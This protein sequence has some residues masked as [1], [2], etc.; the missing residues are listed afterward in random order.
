MTSE[1]LKGLE[2]GDNHFM[3]YTLGDIAEFRNGKAI[4]P[5]FYS[6][7]GKHPVFGSNG[8]IARTDEVLNPN[9]VIA[10]GRVG[11]FCG[12]VYRIKESSWVT[13]N[14]IIVEP[15]S[16]TDLVFLYYRLKSLDLNRTAIGSAQP[17]V[18]QSGLKIIRTIIP[19]LPEQKAIASILGALDDKIELN[20]KTND[21]LEA[22]ARA[23]FKSWFTYPFEGVK[24][25]PSP[26]PS[27][28]GRGCQELTGE[29][30][31]Q[32]V[33]S[34]LGKIPKGW[35]MGNLNE[36]VELHRD[37][38]NPISF[39]NEIFE[40]YSIP[41][42]D[43]RQ[44]PTQDLGSTIKSNKFLLP[45][46][47]ILISKLN[48]RIPRIWFPSINKN[49]RSVASTEFLVLVPKVP[50]SCEF[51]YSLCISSVFQDFFISLVTGTSSSHQRVKP[52][53]LLSIKITYPSD[54]IVE[55]F[56]KKVLPL[57]ANIQSTKE[58]SLTLAAIRDALLPKLLSGEIRV[59]DAERFIEG[60]IES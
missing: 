17:L 4:S 48:P 24:G 55:E 47:C 2:M 8:E 26:L 60:K 44:M 50:Y 29:G 33:D 16:N 19:P 6:P 23:I 37:S 46:K 57:F 58:Q 56:T 34:P 25:L 1:N 40:H 27:L 3:T 10:I 53:D 20:R 15:K 21:T 36:I 9:S 35:R 41:A 30:E 22:M 7:Y 14:A 42:F 38:I 28:T 31:L 32:L 45:H 49:C 59:K 12:S 52:E 11:A 54:I 39:P 13:D 18:T 43:E 51:I 5:S